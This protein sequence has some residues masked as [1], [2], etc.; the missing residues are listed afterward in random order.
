VTDGDTLLK[1]GLVSGHDFSRATQHCDGWGRATEKLGF[2]SGH[3]FSRAVN[4]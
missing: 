4:N 3:D 1:N 2:V